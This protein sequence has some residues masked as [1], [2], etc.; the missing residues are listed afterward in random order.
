MEPEKSLGTKRAEE[1]MKKMEHPKMRAL[2]DNFADAFNSPTRRE[3][4]PAFIK[5]LELHIPD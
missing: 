2:I 4:P 5:S 3:A 1:T